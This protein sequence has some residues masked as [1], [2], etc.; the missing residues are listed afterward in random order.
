MA[1]PLQSMGVLLALTAG[2]A[3]LPAQAAD[4]AASQLIQM[5]SPVIANHSL[6]FDLPAQPLAD[7]LE[8]F[9]AQAGLPVIF[10]AAL[11]QGRRS[12]P[13]HG[14]HAAMHA[15]RLLLEGS[16]LVAQ[17]ARPGRSDAVVV[18]PQPPLPAE[19]P[20]ATEPALPAAAPGNVMHRRYDGLMQTRVRETFCNHPLLSRGSYR[21]AVQF[22]VDVMGRVHGVRLLDS[23]GDRVRDAAITAGLE[24]MQLDWAPPPT[25]AQ[26]VTL[27]IQPRGAGLCAT[28]P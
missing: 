16:G 12:A 25:M 20:E 23:S 15:L 10:D 18:L 24:G 6:A 27:L 28:A 11:V 5:P 9:G 19:L 26:P 13:V 22:H 1:H 8:Q 17:Y 7:A 14:P 3:G 21:T 4:N 2:V